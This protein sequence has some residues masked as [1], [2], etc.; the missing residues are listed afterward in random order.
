MKLIYFLILPVFLSCSLLKK[1]DNNRFAPIEP[2]RALASQDYAD[3]LHELKTPYLQG[4][5]ENYFALSIPQDRYLKNLA[6][7]IVKNNE[8]FF[9]SKDE[10]KFHIIKSDI[11]FF[12]SLPGLEIFLS[13]ALLV[14]YIGSENLLNCVLAYE[15]V[16]SEKK[17]YRKIRLIPT[18]TIS[19]ERILSMLR[20]QSDEKIEI[21]KWAH[22]LLKRS[23]IDADFYLS[24]L[25][26]QNRNS[27]DFRFQ[28]GD[29][30]S[31]TREE[32]LFKAYLVKSSKDGI[33]SDKTDRSSKDFYRFQNWIKSKQ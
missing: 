10:V 29:V 24:W 22:Y 3:H 18:E 5:S 32:A 16:R 4:Q 30:R 9:T 33:I 19:N 26:I 17:V 11:P 23:N 2:P 20:L 7:K 8:L 14:R 25:Q 31:I 15:L 21:H 1:G 12:F 28:L 13:S 6:L 27:L